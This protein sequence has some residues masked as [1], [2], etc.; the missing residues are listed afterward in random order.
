PYM[1]PPA[2]GL[3]PIN[4]LPNEVLADIFVL[5]A[6]MQA[7]E[8]IDLD[9]DAR[10]DA[11]AD[12]DAEVDFE[13]LVSHVCQRWRAVALGTPA[14]WNCVSFSEGPPFE[15][16]RTYIERSREAPL[17]ITIDCTVQPRQTDGRVLP[18][19][20]PAIRDLI[21]PHVGRWRSFECAVSSYA[22]MHSTLLALSSA[23]PAPE[24]DELM[25][26]D[27]GEHDDEYESFHPASLRAPLLPFGGIAPN[28]RHVVLWGV[29]LDWERA[30]FLTGLETLELAYHAR[31]VRPSYAVFARM[32][33]SSPALHRLSL[34]LSCPAGDAD[35]W[36]VTPLPL[37]CVDQLQLAFLDPSTVLALLARLALPAL[38]HL[39]LEADPDDYSAVLHA[40]V[41]SGGGG[42]AQQ[43]E[44]LKVAGLQV[45]EADVRAFYGAM[46]GLQTL[47]LDGLTSSDHFIDCLIPAEDAALLPRLESLTTTG[48]DGAQICAIVETRE[49]AG[50]PLRRVA[51]ASD[52]ELG[53]DDEAW[54]REH[55]DFA[56]FE[57][58]D[59]EFVD[60]QGSIVIE[61]DDFTG[62]E[63]GSGSGSE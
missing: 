60:D 44:S 59:S 49:G 43:L 55:V 56:R 57:D 50:V 63:E 15:R 31:D 25:L 16:S 47:E 33:S 18:E 20:L 8:P 36:P 53:L 29:H 58:E 17:T 61:E 40:L 9:P 42:R 22:V 62:S 14:L 46:P 34:Q 35:D 41:G 3:T 5:G 4:A 19:D 26:Y 11:G 37:P 7:E 30:A 23:G 54:L 51:M 32:L 21:L 38:R 13:V 10:S 28:L 39:A 2:P 12:E 27:H 52:D 24:L 45:E 48:V 1:T 6:D